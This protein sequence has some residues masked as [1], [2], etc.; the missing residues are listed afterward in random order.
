[1]VKVVLYSFVLLFVICVISQQVQAVPYIVS[2]TL[3]ITAATISPSSPTVNYTNP[4][5]GTAEVFGASL[6]S[7]SDAFFANSSN[8]DF[9]LTGKFFFYPQQKKK[10]KIK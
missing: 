10:K 4:I 8:T 7:A 1:M 9:N 3:P 5:K 2:I 6:C